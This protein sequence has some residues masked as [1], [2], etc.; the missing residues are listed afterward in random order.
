VIL[1][2]NTGLSR[3]LLLDKPGIN[4]LGTYLALT[5]VPAST[6]Y[7]STLFKPLA[8]GTTHNFAI[9]K[10]GKLSNLV[11][12]ASGT[13][14]ATGSLE[15]IVWVQ[16]VETALTLTVPA[17]GG[18]GSYENTTDVID[19]EEGQLVR[20]IFRNNATAASTGLSTISMLFH[21]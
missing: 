6:D 12:R 1:I 3:W 14:P 8:D 17:G 5:T 18:S 4:I 10:K 20:W 19:V 21:Y 7:H 15:V 16:G 2:Y 13:Q 11:L 9:P